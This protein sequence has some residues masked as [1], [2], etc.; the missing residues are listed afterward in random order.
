MRTRRA[1]EPRRTA[2]TSKCKTRS[3][4]ISST[5]WYIVAKLVN[6]ITTQMSSYVPT[7]MT[8]H[9]R[10]ICKIIVAMNELRVIS[11][12]LKYGDDSKTPPGSQF[13]ADV[14]LF[15]AHILEWLAPDRDAI[16]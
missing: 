6:V 4:F 7:G 10:D 12:Y 16:A 5:T 3:L 13:M 15:G 8:S 2:F 14:C 9:N 11:S 1:V